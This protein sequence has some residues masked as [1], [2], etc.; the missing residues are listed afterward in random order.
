MIFLCKVKSVF[1]D[2]A[3]VQVLHFVKV[4]ESFSKCL[5]SIASDYDEGNPNMTEHLIELKVKALD[6]YNDEFLV[7]QEQYDDLNDMY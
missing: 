1:D 7:T 4:T 2:A 3:E 5:E 6:L